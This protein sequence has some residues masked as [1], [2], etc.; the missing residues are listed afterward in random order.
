MG[1][2]TGRPFLPGHA[3]DRDEPGT[4]RAARRL[5]GLRLGFFNFAALSW[6]GLSLLIL[7]PILIVGLLVLILRLSLLGGLCIL[8]GAPALR[9]L[10]RR[11]SRL[12]QIGPQLQGLGLA[13]QMQIDLVAL[14]SLDLPAG[15]RVASMQP[16][17][18]LALWLQQ[19]RRALLSKERADELDRNGFARRFCRALALS[20]R[21]T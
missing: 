5:F 1:H 16:A 20:E 19:S 3:A 8:L 2:E 12:I 7:R 21:T 18:V 11:L 9:L 14:N 13:V 6:V 4:D 17:G 15:D 10:G